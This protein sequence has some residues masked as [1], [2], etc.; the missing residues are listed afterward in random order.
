MVVIDE[1]DIGKTNIQ[2]LMDLIY[3]F[4]GIKIPE[5]HIRY[6]KPMPLD[7]RPEI[8]DDPNTFIPCHINP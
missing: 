4:Q 6:G 8:M 1:H 5:E 3:E 7:A 2:I